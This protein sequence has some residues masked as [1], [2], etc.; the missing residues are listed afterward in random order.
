MDS[1][2]WAA[3][4]RVGVRMSARVPARGFG[5]QSFEDRND[6]GGGLAASGCRAREE[7]LAARGPRASRTPGWAS[8]VD[9]RDP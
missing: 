3:S 6:E 5:D 8:A 2:I 7:I 9:S 1:A 4:S